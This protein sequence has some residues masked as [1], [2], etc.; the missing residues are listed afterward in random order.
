MNQLMYDPQTTWKPPS[1]KKDFKFVW[2]FVFVLFAILM[3]LFFTSLGHGSEPGSKYETLENVYVCMD[4][5]SVVDLW[6][7]IRADDLNGIN[8]LIK[9]QR[10]VKI[11]PGRTLQVSDKQPAVKT[12]PAST[13]CY[14]IVSS[15]PYGPVLVWS[16]LFDPSLKQMKK[17]P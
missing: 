10:V 13:Q 9:N 1:P 5:R 6:N 8:R 17:V 7:S 3:F 16:D 2:S 14:L 11:P 15:K 4:A 12:D